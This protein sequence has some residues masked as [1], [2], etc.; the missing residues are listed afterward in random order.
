MDF[1]TIMIILITLVVFVFIVLI[2]FVLKKSKDVKT[3]EF[4]ENERTEL[5]QNLLKK[6]KKLLSYKAELYLQITDAMTFTR[7][8]AVTNEKISGLLYNKQQKPII[9]F[10]RVERS[11]NTTGQLIAMTKKQEFVYEF[12]GM[13]I[14]LFCDDILLGTWDKSGILYDANKKRFGQ[15]KRTAATTDTQ[16]PLILNNRQIA[17][18]KKAPLYDGITSSSVTQV[19]DELNFGASL[20]TL[21]DIPNPTEENWLLALTIFE[22]TFYGNTTVH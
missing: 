20:L 18:I 17:S 19:F 15:F 2:A 9:A 4:L 11:M 8:T 10:E 22:I 5:R 16:F 21:D 1:F 6:R 13:H 7:T 12:Q 3:Q 14:K